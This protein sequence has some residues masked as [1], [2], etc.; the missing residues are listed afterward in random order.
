V[1]SLTIKIKTLTPIWTG[2]A[3]GHSRGNLQMSG[4]MG[5]MRQAFEMLVRM[6]GGTTCDCTGENKCPQEITENGE[7]KKVICPACAVFGCTGL[8]RSFRLRVNGSKPGVQMELPIAD[9][10]F[11]SPNIP[12]RKHTNIPYKHPCAITKWLATGAGAPM[13]ANDTACRQHLDKNVKV[14]PTGE[15]DLFFDIIRPD[16]NKIDIDALFRYLLAFMSRYGGLGAK[17]NQ[18]WG[19]FDYSID[20]TMEKKG[21]DG[22]KNLISVWYVPVPPPSRRLPDAKDSFS[23]EWELPV[24]IDLGFDWA[25][26]GSKSEHQ[27]GYGIKY[28]LRRMVKF[29]G[30]PPG[31]VSSTSGLP[32]VDHL[33]FVRYVFGRDNA[34][35]NNKDC[36]KVGVSHL[37]ISSG[38]KTRIRLFG[39]LSNSA[40][41]KLWFNS[42]SQAG[43]KTPVSWQSVKKISP[44]NSCV[45]P[46]L[47]IDFITGKMKELLTEKIG[48][49]LLDPVCWKYGG[50]L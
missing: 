6:H 28:R 2:D 16:G 44:A 41:Q 27:I 32:W 30:L 21:I 46:P 49:S 45:D 47:S 19:V 37:L 25:S 24:G 42:L 33:D 48:G 23:A 38:N 29:H 8:A 40:D 14:I 26:N 20:N 15:L 34:N 4:I 11:K 9:G 39:N 3:S 17:C 18:G 12:N 13:D 1:E 10:K 7:K 43:L 31:A 5:G 22:I 50:E 36:G 35:D